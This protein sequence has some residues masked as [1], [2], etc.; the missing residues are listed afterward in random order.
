MLSGDGA[1]RSVS[2]QACLQCNDGA[3]HHDRQVSTQGCA[4]CHR[5][6]RGDAL[7]ARVPDAQCTACHGKL[8]TQD[9]QPLPDGRYGVV[10]TLDSLERLPVRPSATA[11]I[12]VQSTH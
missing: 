3:V 5:E 4:S 7:L 12:E 1:V 8:Q 6:H 9:G 10:A 11:A 2:D